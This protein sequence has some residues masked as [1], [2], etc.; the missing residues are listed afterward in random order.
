MRH[1]R[2]SPHGL[3]VSSKL[4]RELIYQLVR[5]DGLEIPYEIKLVDNVYEATKGARLPLIRGRATFGL[6]GRRI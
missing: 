2:T 5:A 3:K 6:A 1:W 4:G